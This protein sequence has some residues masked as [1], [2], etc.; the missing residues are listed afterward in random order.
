MNNL[1]SK[2]SEKEFELYKKILE[3]MKKFKIKLPV[4]QIERTQFLIGTKIVNCSLKN[5]KIVIRVGGGFSSLEK[6]AINNRRS[7][8]QIIA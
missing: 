7:C 1:I 4:R 8:T 2:A 6:F 5:E 3:T